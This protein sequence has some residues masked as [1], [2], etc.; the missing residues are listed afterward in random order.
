MRDRNSCAKIELTNNDLVKGE[1]IP[2]EQEYNT[3]HG[4]QAIPDEASPPTLPSAASACHSE[5]HSEYRRHTESVRDAV[6]LNLSR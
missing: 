5:C 6:F 3:R 1:H 4:L 2:H